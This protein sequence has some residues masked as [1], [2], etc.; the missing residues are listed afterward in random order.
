MGVFVIAI[1]SKGVEEEQIGYCVVVAWPF[2][3]VYFS[4]LLIGGDTA[5]GCVVY[6]FP[7]SLLS[8]ST[9]STLTWS[10]ELEPVVQLLFITVLG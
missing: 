8:Q 5:H 4:R 9:R 10:L 3:I 2:E 6:L 7:L 1:E